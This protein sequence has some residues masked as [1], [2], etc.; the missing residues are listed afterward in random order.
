[1]LNRAVDCGSAD[2]HLPFP[3]QDWFSR[4][5]LRIHNPLYLETYKNALVF[6]PLSDFSVKRIKQ[7]FPSFPSRNLV[8]P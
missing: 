6:A 2:A 4:F 1:M 8:S 3:A 5:V 7:Y